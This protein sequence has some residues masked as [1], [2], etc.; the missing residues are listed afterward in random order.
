M[1]RLVY[2]TFE[3]FPPITGAFNDMT[4]NVMVVL[5]SEGEKNG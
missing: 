1:K 4:E 2:Y 3:A 5:G